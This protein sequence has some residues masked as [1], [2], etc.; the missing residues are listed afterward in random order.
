MQIPHQMHQIE[1][2]KMSD[3]CELAAWCTARR[4]IQRGPV[5]CS[6]RGVAVLLGWRRSEGIH[7]AL[8]RV[9]LS[10][11]KYPA[12]EAWARVQAWSACVGGP[13]MESLMLPQANRPQKQIHNDRP[14]YFIINQRPKTLWPP[15]PD[16]TKY[17]STFVHATPL[18][19]W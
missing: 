11:S 14:R 3:M 10:G 1:C 13:N 12:T 17:T 18:S 9:V 8:S 5:I 6:V 7:V 16:D 15:F 4:L 2:R 19:Q